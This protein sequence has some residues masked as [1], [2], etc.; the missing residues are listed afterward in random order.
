MT[1][2]DLKIVVP[3]KYTKEEY[4]I[5]KGLYMF[6][7]VNFFRV[8]FIQIQNTKKSGWSL[9]DM[10][11]NELIFYL[12]MKKLNQYHMLYIYIRSIE[13]PELFYIYLKSIELTDKFWGIS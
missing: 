13:L 9:F 10:I 7:Q 2:R 6:L 8:H 5:A 4:I 11:F 1:I 3:S 12:H